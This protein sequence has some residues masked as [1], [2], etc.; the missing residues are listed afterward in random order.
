MCSCNIKCSY[1]DLRVDC[2]NHTTS[3]TENTISRIFCDESCCFAFFRE[4]YSKRIEKHLENLK[5][6]REDDLSKNTKKL[7]NLQI[8]FYSGC[9]NR[10][11]KAQLTLLLDCYIKQLQ[12]LFIEEEEDENPSGK[13]LYVLGCMLTPATIAPIKQYIDFFG[14]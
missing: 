14:K 10:Q 5:Y 13:N 3:T 4:Y 7:I 1:C 8:L 11:T 2:R 12:T 9:L 6:E